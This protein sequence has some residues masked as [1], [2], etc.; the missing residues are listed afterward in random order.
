[1]YRTDQYDV[2]HCMVEQS[3]RKGSICGSSSV[4]EAVELEELSLFALLT[5]PREKAAVGSSRSLQ[6]PTMGILQGIYVSCFSR[7][8]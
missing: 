4:N 6:S 5:G 1:M 7:M 2:H 8:F 3:V